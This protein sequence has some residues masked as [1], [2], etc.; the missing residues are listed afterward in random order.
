MLRCHLDV[1]DT[2]KIL[3]VLARCPLVHCWDHQGCKRTY[4]YVR[5]RELSTFDIA[6]TNCCVSVDDVCYSDHL[7]E[8]VFDRCVSRPPL[9]R[10]VMTARITT[11]EPFVSFRFPFLFPF[12]VFFLCF[13]VEMEIASNDNAWQMCAINGRAINGRCLVTKVAKTN[14]RRSDATYEER[15]ESNGNAMAE[16]ET[17]PR[18][19]RRCVTFVK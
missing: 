15:N 17:K 14:R 3:F 11:S 18:E 10:S 1:E 2:L 12:S 5:K 9:F 19:S 16:E 4:V 6:D 13:T 8:P 7:V